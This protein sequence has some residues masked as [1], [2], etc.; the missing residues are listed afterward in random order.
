MAAIA[1]SRPQPLA[2]HTLIQTR[3]KYQYV[4]MKEMLAHALG[5]PRGGG[6]FS[7]TGD[8]SAQQP[9]RHLFQ[10][11]SADSTAL[12]SP[13]SATAPEVPATTDGPAKKPSVPPQGSG[14]QAR[15]SAQPTP[16]KKTAVAAGS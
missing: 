2:T 12:T 9:G 10:P 7:T 6:L 15:P 13:V 14:G 4:R 8:P 1:R 16:A 5:G 3:K 11:P